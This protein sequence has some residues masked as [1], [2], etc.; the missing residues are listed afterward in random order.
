MLELASDKKVN[1]LLFFL[2]SLK[3]WFLLFSSIWTRLFYLFTH[4]DYLCVVNFLLLIKLLL[5]LLPVID[6]FF[7]LRTTHTQVCDRNG[8][9]QCPGKWF[10]WPIDRSFTR[11]RFDRTML[12]II[13]HHT[14]RCESSWWTYKWAWRQRLFF[15]HV[16]EAVCQWGGRLLKRSICIPI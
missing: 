7:L 3:F 12:G 9:C 14:R 15:Q 2:T 6:L 11:K 5:I 1:I 16:K 13:C 10:G 4:F 8:W